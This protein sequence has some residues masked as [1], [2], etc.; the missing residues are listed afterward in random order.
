MKEASGTMVEMS[1]FKQ[2]AKDCSYCVMIITLHSSKIKKDI[3]ALDARLQGN[4][5]SC[6]VHP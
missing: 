6:A 2:I 4:K 5:L 1:T 3:E